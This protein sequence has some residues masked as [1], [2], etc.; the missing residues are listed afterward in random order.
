MTMMTTELWGGRAPTGQSR[1][2]PG[3]S[4]T[5]AGLAALEESLPKEYLFLHFRS[6]LFGLAG[7]N[8]QLFF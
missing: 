3:P 4:S 7:S 8:N 6:L 5:R 1:N 2:L